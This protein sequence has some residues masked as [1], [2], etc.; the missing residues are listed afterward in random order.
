MITVVMVIMITVVIFIMVIV[1]MFVKIIM[2]I[3]VALSKNLSTLSA[4]PTI[5]FK[6]VFQEFHIAPTVT[7]LE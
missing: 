2:I 6:L 4:V 3:M 1:I 5:K 7:V